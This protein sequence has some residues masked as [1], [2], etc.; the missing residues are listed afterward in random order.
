MIDL[1]LLTLAE[2][3]DGL[4]TGAFDAIQLLHDYERRIEAVDERIHAYLARTPHQAHAAAE[5]A[6][7][8]AANDERLGPLDGVPI[9]IKDNI[10][11]VGVPTT[12]GFAHAAM[13]E[14][15][16]VVIANLR[17]AGAVILGKLNMH[18]G[19]LGATTDNPHHGRTEN[20]WAAGHTAAGSSG[21]SGAAV[22]GRLAAATLGSDTMGS[23]RLPAAYCGVVGL[24]PS[25]GVVPNEGVHLLTDGLDHVGP[26][27]RTVADA[28]LMLDGM[29]GARI[30]TPA[31]ADLAGL[32]VA[33]LSNYGAVEIEPDIAAGFQAALTRIDGAGGWIEERTLAGYQPH[34]ARRAGLLMIEAEGWVLH[35]SA[36]VQRRAAYS[37]EFLKM[38][39][40]G[41][42]VA[43]PRL[44][45]ATITVR[46]VARAFDTLLADVDVLAAPA[47]A[48]VAFPFGAPVPVNQA[49]L[50]ALANFSGAP[51]ISL[52]M[53]LSGD[54]L[55]MS[56]QLTAA[57]GQDRRL[58]DI[59]QAVEAVLPSIGLPG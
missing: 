11:V 36:I 35:E 50:T 10:D 16:A 1:T 7:A 53:G 42:D 5:A 27:A 57:R 54:H 25:F 46:R 8:R 4:A 9:A 23:V 33:T 44:T 58:L 6:A 56:L 47:A 21:G 29:T 28:A 30:G 20:P 59:A 51:S 39:E 24:K 48:Q 41:R 52:P 3:A 12:N 31:V 40:Y 19:A 18:E 13:P 34:D 14:A 32:R 26:L 15:D 49:D 43:A 38:L 45:R 55:P 17:A 37:L 2:A 22:A